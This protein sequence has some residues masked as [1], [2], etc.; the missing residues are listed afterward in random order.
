MPGRLYSTSEVA[1]LF[2]VNR[3]TVYRWVKEG[4][5]RAYEIGKHFK[6]SFPEVER[7]LGEF[8]FSEP[9]ICDICKGLNGGPTDT[10]VGYSKGSIKKLVIAVDSNESGLESIRKMFAKPYLRNISQLL[11]FSNSLD[12]AIEIGRKKPDMVLLGVQM[13]DRERGDLAAKIRFLYEDVRIV[14]ISSS[15]KGRISK[16]IDQSDISGYLENR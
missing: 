11:T 15:Q 8:G 4:K 2:K 13:S 10:D 16:Q 1:R 5:I 6:I 9:D 14:M 3:V 12:A 7:L